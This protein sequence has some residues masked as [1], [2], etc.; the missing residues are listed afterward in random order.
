MEQ[1]PKCTIEIKKLATF[2][3]DEQFVVVILSSTDE[4]YITPSLV[5]DRLFKLINLIAVS[6]ADRDLGRI[7]YHRNPFPLTLAVD[8]VKTDWV[9]ALFEASVIHTDGPEASTKLNKKRNRKKLQKQRQ[10]QRKQALADTAPPPSPESHATT[11]IHEEA[12]WLSVDAE[13]RRAYK[14]ELNRDIHWRL[15]GFFCKS[16]LVDFFTSE[17]LFWTKYGMVDAMDLHQPTDAAARCLMKV[18]MCVKMRLSVQDKIRKHNLVSEVN[19]RM[20]EMQK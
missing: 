10:K 19:V 17:L 3:H 4:I 14:L 18:N 11:P 6:N 1:L 8:P 15:K 5:R 9:D 16:E 2:L 13:I 12:V 7:A 20:V